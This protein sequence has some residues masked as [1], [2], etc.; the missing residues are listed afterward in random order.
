[1]P[2]VRYQQGVSDPVS[3]A[4][5]FRISA[6]T[7]RYIWQT[8]PMFTIYIFPLSLSSRIIGNAWREIAKR[9]AM[10][11]QDRQLQVLCRRTARLGALL[12]TKQHMIS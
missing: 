12:E 11:L 8:P 1:V 9:L 5:V 3:L 4:W 2:G 7:E 6:N 10:P